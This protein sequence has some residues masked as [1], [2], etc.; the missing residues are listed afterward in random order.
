MSAGEAPDRY[1]FVHIQKTGGIALRERLINH[2]GARAVY[3]AR[4]VD[5][6]DPVELV[7]SV[8][9]LRR[10]L[11]ARGDEIRVVA[12]HF[13]LCTAELLDGE[14]TTLTLLREPVARTLSYLRHHRENVR[15]DRARSLEEIYD[16][17]SRFHGFVE[18]HMTRM[19]SLTPAEI[20]DRAMLTRVRMGRERLE[21]AK[22]ALAR[23]DA[24][25]LQ[26]R[27]EAFCDELSARFGWQLGEPEV[28]N[29]SAPTE[30]SDAFRARIAEEN[31]LDV[32]LY[33]FAKE[34]VESRAF[35]VAR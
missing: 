27:F 2:F 32:E 34:L 25:G 1:L 16:D 3:P 28:V 29:A 10:R 30:V 31:A 12:G 18:N 14:W 4:G 11:A 9:H 13:P 33:E 7:L 23:V 24:V 17:P 5:G 22:E 21:R 35:E 20:A 8:D 15:A 19:L 6:E 26:E